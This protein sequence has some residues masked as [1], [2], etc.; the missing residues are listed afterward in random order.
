MTSQIAF[1]EVLN[2]VCRGAYDF[3]S[4]YHTYMDSDPCHKVLTN[5]ALPKVFT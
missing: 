5:N 1:F 2:T 3:K 4:D